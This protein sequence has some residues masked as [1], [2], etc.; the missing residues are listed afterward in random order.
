MRQLL[1][2][3]VSEQKRTRVLFLHFMPRQCKEGGRS[4]LKAYHRELAFLLCTARL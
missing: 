4:P 2:R 1:A 3:S